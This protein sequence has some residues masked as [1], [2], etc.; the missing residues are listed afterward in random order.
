SWKLA[1]ILPADSNRIIVANHPRYVYHA[2]CRLAHWRARRDRSIRSPLLAS[3]PSATPSCER[4]YTTACFQTV[5]YRAMRAPITGVAGFFMRGRIGD[6]GRGDQVWMIKELD[7]MP[8]T[9]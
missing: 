9:A 1:Q 6:G 4:N 8:T 2:I 7:E 3:D 5:C